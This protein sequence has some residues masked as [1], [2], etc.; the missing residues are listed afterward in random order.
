MFFTIN[1][2]DNSGDVDDI[3]SYVEFYVRIY[4]MN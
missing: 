4:Q 3:T 1:L 2:F